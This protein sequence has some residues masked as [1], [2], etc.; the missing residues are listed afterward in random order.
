[1]TAIVLE[2]GTVKLYRPELQHGFITPDDGGRD[3]FVH[4]KTLAMSRIDLL[5]AGDRV[6]YRLV[7]DN[8]GFQAHHVRLV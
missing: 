3:I 4:A 2:R 1:M 6:E 7:A 5:R 8:R